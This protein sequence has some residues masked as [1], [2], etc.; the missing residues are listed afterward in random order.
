MN[1]WRLVLKGEFIYSLDTNWS[2]AAILRCASCWGF[3]Y[4]NVS[5]WLE[6]SGQ[7]KGCTWLSQCSPYLEGL[8]MLPD[9]S[10]RGTVFIPV[11]LGSVNI[12][13]FPGKWRQ[14]DYKSKTHRWSFLSPFVPQTHNYYSTSSVLV[15]L[16]S[17]LQKICGNGAQ[18]S[19]HHS[20]VLFT[21]M[22]LRE[23][24]IQ[25]IMPTVLRAEHQLNSVL[26]RYLPGR[27]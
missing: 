5:C 8:A 2:E 1:I 3:R 27:E 14:N 12:P 17:F 24:T 21:V 23:Q 22:C 19:L 25:V 11:K 6:G 26:W 7:V 20:K 9:I 10:S 15:H 18:D 13:P 4:C 16:L